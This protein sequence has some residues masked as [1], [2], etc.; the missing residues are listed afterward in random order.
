MSSP[1]DPDQIGINEK[2]ARKYIQ[3]VTSQIKGMEIPVP[4][5]ED[6]TPAE[7]ETPLAAETSAAEA[8]Q[9]AIV[10]K[11]QG[12]SF[13]MPALRPQP[14]QR[15]KEEGNVIVAK[16]LS[17][18]LGTSPELKSQMRIDE[19]KMGV[20]SSAEVPA[21]AH[22]SYRY[23]YDH[24]RY[25]GHITEWQLTGSQGVGG[26]ARKHILQ[27]LA[28]TSGVQAMEKAKKPNVIARSLW[29]RN[30]KEKAESQGQVVEE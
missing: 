14:Q 15:I 2:D 17:E 27:A 7:P 26:L 20:F 3:K 5:P 18:Q 10:Q 8:D 29:D 22:F 16:A 23:V 19:R 28:N 30:W 24:V 4:E 11:K 21:L 25:W 6:P 9:N 13:P 1:P 12:A